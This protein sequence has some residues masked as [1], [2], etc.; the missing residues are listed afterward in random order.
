[1]GQKKECGQE[2]EALKQQ[3]TM[4]R[5]GSKQIVQGYYL[6]NTYVYNKLDRRMAKRKLKAVQIYGSYVV[7][8][9]PASYSGGPG[10]DSRP[11]ILIEAFRGFMQSIQANAG[12]IP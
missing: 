6:Y 9:T 5:L 11:A 10:F 7:D 1:M 3:L 4:R 12:I 8:N 2:T